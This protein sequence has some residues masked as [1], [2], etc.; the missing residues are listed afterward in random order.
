LTLL[1]VALVHRNFSLDGSLE[2]DAVLLARSL[3]K[4]GLDVHF[5]DNPETRAA[6]APGVT[7]HD[8]HPLTV[9]N[10][11]LGWPIERGSFA[12]RATRKLQED[13]S[14]YDIIH[15]SGIA[16]WTHDVVT[17]HAVT[18]A[19]QRRW[20]EQAGPHYRAARLRSRVAPVLRPQTALTRTVERLQFRPGR[21][22]R[23]LAVTDEVRQ[24][25]ENVHRVPHELIDVI[26]YAI[27]LERL[28]NGHRDHARAAL[29]FD[30]SALLLLFVGHG[31]ERKGLREIIKALP[32]L[33]PASHLIV[34]GS[35]DHRRYARTAAN[36][37]VL[38]RVHFVGRTQTPEQFYA[39][40]DLLVLPTRYEPWG[41]PIIEAMAAGIPV[42]TTAIAG[43]AAVV[44]HAGAGVVLTEASSEAV[45]NAIASLLHNPQLRHA[46]GARGRA[47]AQ[48]FSADER[49]KRVL[50]AY[51]RAL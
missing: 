42:I 20:V 49:A 50:E 40:A 26:P 5:Y 47:A 11:R 36:L 4:L 46:M 33:D 22:R 32:A 45:K 44:E 1:R 48:Q 2:R 28:A 17:V 24:D 41:L 27:D 19:G 7:F 8:V 3:V 18:T 25:L 23:V 6:E 21:Y 30:D 13:R 15:V 43:A 39:A 12:V 16:A 31:F 14:Q 38:T 29:G 9:S 35:G 10:S 51:E 37:G 34:V